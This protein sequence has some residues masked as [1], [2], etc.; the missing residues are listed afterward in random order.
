MYHALAIGL[1]EEL[2]NNLK[3]HLSKFDLHLAVSPTLKDAGRLL[4]EK[5]IHLLIWNT[6]E[7][8]SKMNGS[9]MSDISVLYR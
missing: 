1:S 5:V 2:F 3:D 7:V 8:S 9:P 4:S 6:Y